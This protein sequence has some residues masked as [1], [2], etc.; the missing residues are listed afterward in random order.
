MEV[1]VPICVCGFS[2]YCN[3][4]TSSLGFGE[5]VQE[6]DGP[7]LVWLLYGEFN[8]QGQWSLSIGAFC[9]NF[10]WV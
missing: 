10:P 8:M 7:L 4:N 9:P 2:V 3:S 6:G 1:Q 5:G